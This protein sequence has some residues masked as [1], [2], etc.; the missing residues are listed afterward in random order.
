MVILAY[1]FDWNV[2]GPMLPALLDGL[3]FTVE[4]TL[5]VIA[6][7]SL[8]AIPV[9]LA[10]MSAYELL[11]W[12]A[13]V[14]IEI[15][16]GTPMLV[17]L[18]WVF[19]ALPAISGI[20]MSAFV[21]V[22]LALGANLTAFLAEAYRAGLQGVP[23]EHVEAAQVLGLS[24]FDVLRHV[25]IPQALRMQIPV[26]LSLDITLFKDT[27]LVSAL[28]V[29]DLTYVGG[30]Q[31]SETFRPLEIYTTIAVMY[32]VIAFPT[33]LITSALERRLLKRR[34]TEATSPETRSMLVKMLPVRFV[35]GG[36]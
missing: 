28:G 31:A 9:A 12:P 32:F 23:H 16:R 27:S 22:A 34:S 8:A 4:L 20:K 10:R 24:R 6:V 5:I 35:R 25:T 1:Q 17:Q 18:I 13:Q 15:F 3:K 14:Y 7:S 19:Y 26:I 36:T 2:I 33:T 11:R 29:H 21:S 30:I